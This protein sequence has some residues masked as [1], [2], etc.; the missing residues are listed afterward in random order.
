MNI[1]YNVVYDVQVK[2]YDVMYY[3]TY[4]I[5]RLTYDIPLFAYDV[6]CYVVYDVLV[7]TYNVVHDV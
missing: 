7:I 3:V 2:T 4:D 6:V 1:A 5:V